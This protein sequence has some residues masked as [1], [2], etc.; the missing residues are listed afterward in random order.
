[1]APPLKCTSASILHVC[2]LPSG[3]HGD[4]R[5]ESHLC[6]LLLVR[7]KPCCHDDSAA[8][9]PFCCVELIVCFLCVGQSRS[10]AL[11]PPPG[12]ISCPLVENCAFEQRSCC[13]LCFPEE[14][15]ARRRSLPSH[16]PA[17]YSALLCNTLPRLCQS[18]SGRLGQ[19]LAFIFVT[20]F[21]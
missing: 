2:A 15:W 3:Y 21:S 6:R 12:P 8:A 19:T 10:P 13:F 16:P 4:A 1:M 18:L 7:P 17:F 5:P 9:R 11:P 14:E 20:M